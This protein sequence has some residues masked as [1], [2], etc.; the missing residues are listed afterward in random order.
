MYTPKTFRSND[1][2]MLFDFIDQNS[3]ALLVSQ[4]DGVPIATHL[5]ILLDRTAGETGTLF[6]HLARENPQWRMTERRV[7]VVF[8]GP[9]A[10]VS[11]TWYAADN[12][13]PTWNYVAVHAY[14]VFQV[15][16]DHKTT[17]QMLRSLTARFEQSMPQPW[18][19]SEDDA[20]VDKLAR[21]IVAFQIEIE[22][23]EGTWKL[24]QNHSS[25]RR[26]RVAEALRKQSDDNAQAIANLMESDILD[27]KHP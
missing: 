18:S 6:G 8:S 16:D 15:I 9:H 5:P 4:L 11:P 26:H 24:S 12:V 19:F 23:L 14:G 13:V 21:G 27:V 3:F 10:Y 1:A 7:M 20:Y 17:V 22:R 2:P 25:E